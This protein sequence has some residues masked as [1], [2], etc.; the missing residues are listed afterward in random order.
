MLPQTVLEWDG[1]R[2]NTM[3]NRGFWLGGAA[4]ALFL[5]LGSAQAQPRDIRELSQHFTDPGGNIAPWRFVPENNAKEISTAEH[6]GL[7]TIWE[8]GKGQD[9]KGVLAEPI[10][11]GDYPLPWEFQMSLMKNFDAAAGVGSRSQINFA[12]G[13]NLAINFSDPATW[14]T[15]RSQLPP[16]TR[17]LQ[18]LVVHLGLTGEAGVGLPQYTNQPWP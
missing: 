15:D 16:D 18:L 3:L 11:I 6:P 5:V 7:A 1:K 2:R 4:L 8:A 17:S 9:V 12:M 14:P 10:R 13:M